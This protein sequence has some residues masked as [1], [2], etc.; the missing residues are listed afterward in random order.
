LYAY[1]HKKEMGELSEKFKEGQY[2]DRYLKAVGK[3]TRLQTIL[4]GWVNYAQELSQVRQLQVEHDT[5][6]SSV[7]EG[8]SQLMS[9][10]ERARGEAATKVGKWCRQTHRM[11]A[12]MTQVRQTRFRV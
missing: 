10:F 1:R 3:A 4:D 5:T 11:E 2:E 8:L 12:E 9:E 7:E 6:A